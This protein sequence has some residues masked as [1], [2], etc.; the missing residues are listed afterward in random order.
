[1]YRSVMP[2]SLAFAALV[3]LALASPARA[4]DLQETLSEVGEVY[5][6][7]YMAPF[8][9]ALG[10]DL[11][12]GLFHTAR[13]G[14]KRI[15]LHFYLGVKASAAMLSAS[16]RTFDLTYTGTVPMD[17]D[18]GA[19]TITLDVPATFTVTDAPSIFGEE[20]AAMA[21]VRVAHDTTFKT[22]GLVLPV[23]FDSTLA[24]REVIGGLLPTNVAPLLV[25]Q[26]GLGTVLGTDLMIRWL[27]TISIT[28]VGSVEMFGLAVRHS[29]NQYIPFLPVDVAIQAAW[30]RVQVDDASDNSVIDART[31]AVNAAVSKRISVLTLYAGV[32]TERSD[33][34]F[35]YEFEVDDDDVD[36][37]TIPID[38]VVNGAARTRGIFGFGLNLGPVHLNGDVSVGP[39]T[40]YSAGFG[41]AF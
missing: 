32:Q 7:A 37:E 27:P 31:F 35:A 9:D 1:M 41:F 38:F 28:D 13:V 11:N 5:A 19:E 29:I 18:I 25:P 34:A 21:Q 8:A 16:S 14:N 30:Q 36:V 40:V 22:L 4:Q 39:I 15:G 26:V 33:I 10:A 6:R 12:T 24:P 20:E 23:R 3:L 2:R 17:I